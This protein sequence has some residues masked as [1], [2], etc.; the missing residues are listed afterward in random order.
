MYIEIFTGSDEGM[1]TDVQIGFYISDIEINKEK[2]V[3]F[4]HF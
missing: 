2:R 1:P 4:K 3:T